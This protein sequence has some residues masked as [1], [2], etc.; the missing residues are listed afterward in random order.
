MHFFDISTSKSA[1]DLKCFAHF[2]LDTR[3]APQWRALFR[4]LNFQKWSEN[5]VPG[6][7]YNILTWK[8]ASHHRGMHFF[9]ISTS[10]NARTGGVLHLVT[11]TCTSRHNG[12]QFFIFHLGSWLR[13]R[14]FSEPTCGPTRAT[15]HGKKTRCFP[16]LLPFRTLVSS[17]L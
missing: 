9:D 3:L 11:W 17:F 16:T 6:G 8:C 10:K 7:A 2:D 14:R 1:P 12:V 15:K 4:H 13:T 5:A